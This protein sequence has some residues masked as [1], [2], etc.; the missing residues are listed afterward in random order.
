MANVRS[1][2]KIFDFDVLKWQNYPLS[3][4]LKSDQLNKNILKLN[5]YKK[6]ST[7]PATACVLGHS[8]CNEDT[9]IR[10]GYIVDKHEFV[11]CWQTYADEFHRAL[12]A[13]KNKVEFYDSLEQGT[14][15]EIH[16]N[17]ANPIEHY[18][19]TANLASM[20]TNVIYLNPKF[21][22]VE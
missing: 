14:N 6:S 12:S 7:Q 20:N 11:F 17:P 5:D 15:F 9:F 13:S 4:I 1:P 8:S 3:E 22:A 2:L 10:Y 19:T 18:V 21:K 16:Y